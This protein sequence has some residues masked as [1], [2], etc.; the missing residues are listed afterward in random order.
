MGTKFKS[1]AVDPILAKSV[2]TFRSYPV[3]AQTYRQTDVKRSTIPCV[4]GRRSVSAEG[5]VT[6]PFRVNDASGA[7]DV[8]VR[9]AD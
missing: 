3:H 8:R 7:S 1:H 5:R 2:H 4:V 6:T 9:T